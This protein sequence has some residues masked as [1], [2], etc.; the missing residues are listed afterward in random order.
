[1]VPILIKLKL[2]T[3]AMAGW[4]AASSPAPLPAQSVAT[5]VAVDSAAPIAVSLFDENEHQHGT[6]AI[7]R[8]GSTDAA[9][10]TEVKQLFRCRTTHRQKMMA[11]KTLAMLADIAQHYP[12]KTIE[13]VSAYRTGRHESATS[14]HR[15]GRAIDFRIRGVALQPIRDYVW[16]T[17]TDVGVGWYPSEQF[18][19]IDTRPKIH[20]TSWTFYKG[21]NHYHPYWAELARRPQL[22]VAASTVP[23]AGV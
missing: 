7:W 23:R 1:M 15:D 13:Y 18:I 12:G 3:T 11:K 9:T 14:P 21:V 8:D 2:M 6:I 20:D 17:Y 19:H 16:R 10:S 22:P 4:T 5:V